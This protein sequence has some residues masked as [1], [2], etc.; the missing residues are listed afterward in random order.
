MSESDD[1]NVIFL[2]EDCS[3]ADL[4]RAVIAKEEGKK[5]K[6]VKKEKKE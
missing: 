1:S 3:L 5:I 6:F 2:N 4:L